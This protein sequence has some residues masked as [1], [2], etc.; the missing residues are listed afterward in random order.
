MVPPRW[1]GTIVV[2]T[3]RATTQRPTRARRLGCGG[4][5]TGSRA[6]PADSVASG[7]A[8][9]GA[10]SGVHVASGSKRVIAPAIA[11]DAGPRFFWYATPS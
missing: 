7:G 3:A 10:G 8:R 5:A 2:E 4:G 11:A 9:Q 1:G 6:L